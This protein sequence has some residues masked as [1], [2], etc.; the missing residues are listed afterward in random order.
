MKAGVLALQGDFREHARALAD[1][2]ASVVEVRNAEDLSGVDCLVDPGRRIHDD[3]Q[4]GT[5][6]R[7]RG[8]RPRACRGRHADLRDV[9]RHDR[10]GASGRRRRAVVRADGYRGA[11]QRVRAPGGFVR[12]RRRRGRA[13]TIRCAGCSSA[14]R[15]SPTS[16]PACEVLAEHEGAPGRAA[17]GEA[18]RIIVPPGAGRRDRAARYLLELG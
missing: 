9:R 13:S 10:A 18:A 4:A 14:H 1:A 8:A 3:R 6:L 2:G 7:T 15:A 12:G 5:R 17:A 11:A 16:A